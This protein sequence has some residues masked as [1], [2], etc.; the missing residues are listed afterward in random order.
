MDQP[1]H[2]ILKLGKTIDEIVYGEVYGEH[3]KSD[4]NSA[5]F[6]AQRMY[7]SKKLKSLCV[8]K[9]STQP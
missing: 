4:L 7:M 8:V 3:P 2:V 6:S 1:F 9:L 5:K